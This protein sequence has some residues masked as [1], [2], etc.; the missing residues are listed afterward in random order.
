MASTNHESVGKFSM[1][2]GINIHYNELS[3]NGTPLIFLHG[4]TSSSRTWEAVAKEFTA[5]YR[6]FTVDLRGHGKSENP[7]RGYSWED[8][9]AE[10]IAQYL[11]ENIEEPAYLVGH[12]LGASVCGPVA[13]KSANRVKAI[14]ME[15]PP[16]FV[17]EK[18]PESLSI[19]PTH[20]LNMLAAKEL[21]FDARVL[22]IMKYTE[23]DYEAAVLR[24]Q[25]IEDMDKAVLVELLPGKT[26]YDP[27]VI[28][29]KISCP[30]LIYLGNPELGGVVDFEDRERLQA[31]LG[32]VTVIERDSVG[33][34]IH[35]EDF[36]FFVSSLEEFL[37]SNG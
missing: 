18:A 34:S 2:N 3:S 21:G 28:F 27:E 25:N 30:A 35:S 7:G 5:N 11:N 37:K 12:S 1:V 6:V 32:Q 14:V 8:D 17:H 26:G 31:L 10:D 24:A 15:D 20:F 36:Q 33:H 22:A 4:V 16:V 13:V 19:P 9:Y 23:C 29:P